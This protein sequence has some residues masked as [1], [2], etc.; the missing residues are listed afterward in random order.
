MKKSAFFLLAFALICAIYWGQTGEVERMANSYVEGKQI[1]PT[2]GSDSDGNFLV[3]WISDQQDDGLPGVYGKWF[4]SDGWALGTEFQINS[5]WA[6]HE[7]PKVAVGGNG[8]FVVAMTNY[9]IEKSVSGAIT[10]RVFDSSGV[11]LDAEFLVNEHKPDFQ[12]APAVAMDSQG[13]FVI[14][15]QS[16]GQDGDG[17]G[18][19]ARRFDSSGIP[20][21]P[22][23]Q[24]NAYF[25]HNQ[26]QPT[27]AMES[28]GNFVIV[29]TSQ[30]QNQEKTGIYAQRFGRTGNFL[31]SEFR[32]NFS[33]NGRHEHPEI[34]MDGLG[35]FTVCWQKY[36]LDELEYKIFAR[37]FDRTAQLKGPEF[38]V[39]SLA[40]GTH[41]F[42][43][44]DRDLLGNF[45]ITWQNQTQEDSYDIVARL[46]NSYGEPQGTEFIVNFYTDKRQIAPDIFFDSMQ[47]LGICWQS[48]HEYETDWNVF[49]RALTFPDGLS[50]RPQIQK[51][52][53]HE[54][55]KIKLNPVCPT[56]SNRPA[57][58]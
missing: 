9:W 46:F 56:V 48:L 23:F 4:T 40:L 38:Q 50:S 54:Y 6:P 20:L 12:G 55:K 49:Y 32:V 17:F 10:A 7:Q 5:F 18:I 13:N 27:I 42:P 25:L 1:E 58:N 35:N 21:G 31:G 33:T 47:N 51:Q 22:E 26:T 2:I 44:I 11:P 28:G 16:W 24:A 14:A 37:N 41:T 43:A 30:R 3:I 57:S 45:V 15:W 8:N 34:S 36:D 19:F 52:K 29:W 53:K 39:N